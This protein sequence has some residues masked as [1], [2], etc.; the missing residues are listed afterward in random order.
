M[1]KV[2]NKHTKYIQFQVENKPRKHEIDNAPWKNSSQ[3]RILR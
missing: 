3:N 2:A 1:K